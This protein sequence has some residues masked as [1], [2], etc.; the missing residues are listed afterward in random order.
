MDVVIDSYRED[1]VEVSARLAT[2]AF[3]IYEP[4]APVFSPEF[5][6]YL[7]TMPGIERDLLLCARM[8]GKVVG[9]TFV[10]PRKVRMGENVLD[11]GTVAV[12]GTDPDYSRRGIAR[13]LM[14]SAIERS[15]EKGL[16]GLI[17]F[18]NPPWNAYRLYESVGFKTFYTSNLLM[19][20]LDAKTVARALGVGYMAPFMKLKAG[21]KEKPLPQG[22]SI[23]RYEARDR[24]DCVAMEQELTRGFDYAEL[25]SEDSWKWWQESMSKKLNPDGYVMERNGEL[26]GAIS[27]YSASIR[28]KNKKGTMAFQ[29]G[30]VGNF[31]YKRGHEEQVQALLARELKLMKQSGVAAASNG[32]S[33]AIFQPTEF[34]STVWK[35]Y[36]F[37]KNKQF[38]QR[39]MYKSL[40]PRFNGLESMKSFF[41]QP[42]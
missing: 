7:W 18:T 31:C 14:E 11:V 35:K 22:F 6:N 19:K 12:V 30:A 36:G 10:L 40:D 1:E 16:H 37:M 8:D 5:F 24:A 2:K 33:P 27:S 25:V 4:I 9:Q 38:E 17:L 13:K 26:V 42:F 28:A 32:Q 20:V 41:I 21:V 34:L 23:R 3:S 29:L 39:F 15:K